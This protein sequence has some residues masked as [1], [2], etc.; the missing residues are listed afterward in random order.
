MTASIFSLPPE[1]LLRFAVFAIALSALLGAEALWPARLRNFTRRRRWPANLVLS[2]TNTALLRFA[3]PLLAVGVALWAQEAGFGLF[4][5][6][7]VPAPAA[8]AASLILLDVVIY[9]QHVAMHRFGLLWRF[10]RVHHTDRDVDVTTAL[11]FHPG[12]IALSMGLKM[13]FVALIGAPPAS[14]IAFEAI[15]NGMAMFNHAN[16]KLP[17]ALDGALRY[18]IVTPDMHRVHHSLDP[19]ETDTNYGFN[20]SLWDR[21]FGT[22]RVAA[23]RADFPLG[24]EHFQTAA[25]NRWGFVFAL[26]FRGGPM[27]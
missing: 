8:F 1:A 16:L 24:L 6:W 17:A 12:E 15:L 2:V 20:L 18:M 22:Y 25:P 23:R 9:G 26:P 5:W 11:R 3:F 10:H 4:H 19:D 7:R 21:L 14:V 27:R 13:A